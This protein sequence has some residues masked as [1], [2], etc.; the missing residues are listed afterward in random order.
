MTGIIVVHETKTADHT[1]IVPGRRAL[2]EEWRK[3][4]I[5]H[6]GDRITVDNEPHEAPAD[7]KPIMAMGVSDPGY[8]DDIIEAQLGKAI[9]RANKPVREMTHDEYTRVINEAFQ[10]WMEQKIRHLRGQTTIGPGGMQQRSRVHQ[11]PA[12]RPWR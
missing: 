9:E 10:A 3:V 2:G 5:G 4:T 11:N 8:I 6:T 7:G 1:L 12:T